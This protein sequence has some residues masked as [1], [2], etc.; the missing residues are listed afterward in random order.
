MN[1]TFN[2]VN[3]LTMMTS[4]GYHGNRD[5]TGSQNNSEPPTLLP[6][7]YVSASQHILIT[8]FKFNPNSKISPR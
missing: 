4:S 3:S 8:D 5:V 1:L 6:R 7:K 2:P